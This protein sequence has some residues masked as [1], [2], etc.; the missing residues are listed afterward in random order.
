MICSR[1]QQPDHQHDA[2]DQAQH[3]A[4]DPGATP[5]GGRRQLDLDRRA[6]N[7]GRTARRL[8]I[9]PQLAGWTGPLQ[10]HLRWRRGRAAPCVGAAVAAVPVTSAIASWIAAASGEY[11]Q[12]LPQLAQRTRRPSPTAASATW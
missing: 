3:E 9:G 4:G 1:R 2:D 8:G 10:H 12:T 11:D 5:I 6:A 7:R